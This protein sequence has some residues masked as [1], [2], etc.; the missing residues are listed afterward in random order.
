MYQ[1]PLG[2]VLSTSAVAGCFLVIRWTKA[3]RAGRAADSSEGSRIVHPLLSYLH[4]TFWT[5]QLTYALIQ[6]VSAA[7]LEPPSLLHSLEA[8][9]NA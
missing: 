9:N 5:A 3:N 8:T 7:R 1:E 4:V 6:P 2:I